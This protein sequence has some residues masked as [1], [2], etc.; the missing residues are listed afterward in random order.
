MQIFKNLSIKSSLTIESSSLKSGIKPIL[1][2]NFLNMDEKN[3]SIVDIFKSLLRNIFKTDGFI[4]RISFLLLFVSS[5]IS[6]NSVVDSRFLRVK[7]I[8][9]FISDAALFVK[10]RVKICSGV[11]LRKSKDMYLTLSA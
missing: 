2:E 1:K 7:K 8:L 3:E 6:F 4:E 9:S 5:Q 10:V 11:D